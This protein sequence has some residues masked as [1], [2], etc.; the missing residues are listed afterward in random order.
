M[1]IRREGV[2]FFSWCKRFERQKLA[3]CGRE[4]KVTSQ[5]FSYGSSTTHS[6]GDDADDDGDNE[7]NHI[8]IIT[9]NNIYFMHFCLH[10]DIVKNEWYWNIYF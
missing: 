5:I 4:K 1:F 2:S 8:T 6:D 7:N 10:N 3:L 9:M